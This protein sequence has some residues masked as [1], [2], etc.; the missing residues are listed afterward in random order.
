MGVSTSLCIFFEGV[1]MS[2]IRIQRPA[3]RLFALAALA[4]ALAGVGAGTASASSRAPVPAPAGAAAKAAVQKEVARI[5]AKAAA[6]TPPSVWSTDN[7]S[8]DW[9]GGCSAAAHADYYPANDQAAIS[10]TVTS[11]YLFAACRVNAQLW[12]D[13]AGGS[14]P[15]AANYAMACAVFDPGCASTQTT[16][17]NYYGATPALTAFVNSVNDALVAAGLPP[18]YTRA[19]AV[20]GVH[21]TFANAS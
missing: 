15:S 2:R 8:S 6:P 9:N 13:T 10:T 20:R 4:T 7:S 12:I 16:T 11:P 5:E 21:L 18:S 3:V 17:G 14:Y 1:P 19:Q